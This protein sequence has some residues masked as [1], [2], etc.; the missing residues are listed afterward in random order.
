MRN[1]RI[2]ARVL[3]AVAVCVAGGVFGAALALSSGAAGGG[4]PVAGDE[5]GV[6]ASGAPASVEPRL[7]SLADQVGVDASDK[8][9]F[10]VLATGLGQFNSRLVAFPARS[11]ENVCYSLLGASQYDPGMSYCYQPRGDNLPAG[12]AGERFSVVALQARIDGVTGTQVFGVAENNVK[13][14]RVNVAGNWRDAPITRNGFYLDL[15]GV[16][17]SDVGIVEATLANGSTQVHD[18]QTGE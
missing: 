15:A 5:F 11:G 12:L 16:P 4:K 3:V 7:V 2:P 1:R 9:H 14:I 6:F 10:R 13:S 17:L 8:S 18:I